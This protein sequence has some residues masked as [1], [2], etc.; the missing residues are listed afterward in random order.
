MGTNASAS[1]PFE[2]GFDPS[3]NN[4]NRNKL[5]FPRSKPQASRDI[6]SGW[7]K[8]I[9]REQL[10]A[11]VR[12]GERADAIFSD[13]DGY[14]IGTQDFQDFPVDPP[15]SQHGLVQARETGEYLAGLA[16]DDGE[17]FHIV[18]SSPY[19]RCVQTAVEICKKLGDHVPLLLDKELGE[20]Y[21]PTIM[22]E[23]QPQ[24]T[25]RPWQHAQ[26]YC[27][28]NGV[29]LRPN[30]VGHDPV[31]PETVGTARER[32]VRRYLKYLHRS[33]TARRNFIIVTHGDHV[34]TG[35]SVLPAQAGTQVEKVE[36]CGCF[37][38][39]RHGSS[40][41]LD[42]QPQRTRLKSEDF[43]FDQHQDSE[44]AEIG[45]SEGWVVETKGLEAHHMGKKASVKRFGERVRRLSQPS[46]YTWT[47]V[48]HLLGSMPETPLS[49]ASP[50]IATRKGTQANFD[51]DHMP[52]ARY[53][54]LGRSTASLSTYLF[55]ASQVSF[56]KI[57]SRQSPSSCSIGNIRS[58]QSPLPSSCSIG[59]LAGSLNRQNSQ[60]C[61]PTPAWDRD[62]SKVL[63]RGDSSK[64]RIEGEQSNVSTKK[65][66]ALNIHV[67]EAQQQQLS[68][69]PASP[70]KEVPAAKIPLTPSGSKLLQRRLNAA[71]GL[72]NLLAPVVSSNKSL[73]TVS[74]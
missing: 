16:A 58:V 23:D 11:V 30:V 61:S 45:I 35:L 9:F 31:W 43:D 7:K 74:L 37:L 38:A 52:W 28:Q 27:A 21:G 60:P 6:V 10:C 55:G 54:D 69:P 63:D 12:H 47:Q 72:P 34:A 40:D 36:Y 18:V 51:D 70:E 24:R 14:W 67:Y 4:N 44:S 59:R 15:L 2:N 65:P 49:L 13:K 57:L 66:I 73:A 33:L 68:T 41:C 17:A 5:Q 50:H 8:R 46:Q 20:I 26:L 71:S 39:R 1:V 64:N 56:S 19:K 25:I 29:H 62:A 22:G 42:T 53:N 3:I 32:F 48:Q